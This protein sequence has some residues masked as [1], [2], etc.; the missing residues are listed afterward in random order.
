MLRKGMRFEDRARRY[1]EGRGLRTL[2]Q[3]FRCRAGEI[4]LIM[5]DGD[6]V[7]FVEVKYRAGPDY[8]GA[9]S[10]IPRRKQRRLIR[11]ALFFLA[12]NPGLGREALRFDALLIEGRGNGDD[13]YEWIRGAFYAE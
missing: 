4:D 7:S 8:G 1:L 11:A 2:R 3:N 13:A 5:R 9:A 10:A 12:R 6:T